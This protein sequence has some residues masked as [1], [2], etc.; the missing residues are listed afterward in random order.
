MMLLSGYESNH[1]AH[2]DSSAFAAFTRKSSSG[3]LRLLEN[4]VAALTADP[5]Q[6]VAVDKLVLDLEE[7]ASS[8]DIFPSRFLEFWGVFREML[9]SEKV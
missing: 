4:I 9:E 2:G 5:S 6:L 1:F 7:G 3:D 8:L